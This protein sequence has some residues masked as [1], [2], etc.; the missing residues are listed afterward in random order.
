MSHLLLEAGLDMQNCQVQRSLK[1]L[2]GIERGQAGRGCCSPGGSGKCREIRYV[3][4]H[5]EGA[6][7]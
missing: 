4:S 3:L 7:T 5:Q 1:E 2:T 6:P